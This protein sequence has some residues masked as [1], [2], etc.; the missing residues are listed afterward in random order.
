MNQPTNPADAGT[1]DTL[2]ITAFLQ[3]HDYQLADPELFAHLDRCE[4]CRR[5][6]DTQ[7]SDDEWRSRV[8][9]LLRPAEFDSAGSPAFSAATIVDSRHHSAVAAQEVLDS[10]APTDH[11]HHLGRIGTYEVTGVIGVGG[12]G[13]VL[14]AIDPA[15]D[16]VVAV[17]VMSPQLAN[18][19]LARKRF[20]REAKAAAAVLHPNV[21]PIHSVAHCDLGP[22]LVMAYIRGSSLQKRL[23]QEGALALV[24][25][26]RI[27]AQIAAGLAAAHEQGLVHR[28]IK[29]ENILLEDGVER[30]TITDFGLARAVDDHT[31]TQNGV[32]AGTPRYMSPEQARGEHVDQQS[33]LFSLGSVLYA[34][35]TG[36]PPFG[37]DSS[38]GVMRRII[39]DTPRPIRE[40][41]PEVPEWLVAIIGR[42]MAKDKSAR[43]ASASEVHTLLETCLGHV[44]QP[45]AIPAPTLGWTA[46]TDRPA[47][48]VSKSVFNSRIGVLMTL[49]ACLSLLAALVFLPSDRPSLTIYGPSSEANPLSEP[50]A[51]QPGP[52]L[53][54][55]KYEYTGSDENGKTLTRRWHMQGESVGELKVSVLHIQGGKSR[56]VCQSVYE[57]GSHGE[58]AIQVELQ[59]SKIGQP[60]PDPGIVITPALVVSVNGLQG[61]SGVSDQISIPGEF[62]T[63][64][65]T[66]S[67]SLAPGHVLTHSA[68]VPG[69]ESSYQPTVDSMLAASGQ[70]LSFLVV[71]VDWR[72]VQEV[73]SQPNQNAAANDHTL[74]AGDWQV[75]YSEDSGRIAPQELLKDLHMVITSDTMTMELGGHQSIFTFELDPR[76]TPKSI[77]MTENG[78]RKQGIYDLQGDTLRICFDEQSDNRPTAFDSQTDSA[79]DVVIML[80]RIKTADL[81][82][83]QAA[84]PKQPAV[85]AGDD[86]QC[87]QGTWQSLDI[88]LEGQQAP[89]KLV[90]STQVIFSDSSYQVVVSGKTTESCSYVLN[91]QTSPKAID[92]VS[93]GHRQLGIYRLD[94][95]LL[96]LWFAKESA[97]VRPT[98]YV[99]QL[100]ESRGYSMTLKRV[101]PERQ[102][103]VET[104]SADDIKVQ[105]TVVNASGQLEITYVTLVESA[106]FCPGAIGEN[107]QHGLEL[108]FVRLPV[109][110]KLSVT[111]PAQQTGQWANKIVVDPRG[112]PVLLRSQG[113]TRPIW[114]PAPQ[115]PKGDTQ[116]GE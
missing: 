79:N 51:A 13:V 45:A 75:V 53:Q 7:A 96:Q 44:Q 18:Q 62:S 27:G 8:A 78:R 83:D 61:R 77:D 28:D 58:Q 35:C 3:A 100:E 69:D 116:K 49:T 41:N 17:K 104:Y 112:Q 68:Y 111:Y 102:P 115:D 48:T 63:H 42:L 92:A 50:A 16:R 103:I 93:E 29:P 10:L 94:G 52:S 23:D 74:I 15:L 57:G 110:R 2:R 14:K 22:Y 73:T 25:V 38:L 65:S 107:T 80:K 12:M 59:T 32:I 1:C 97:P 101:I 85:K 99:N 70:G 20:A 113:E 36:Q 98:G 19:E 72:S 39:D 82:S 106:Y 87:I 64:A 43:F 21:I 11:P 95:D 76:T 26:L 84:E 46:V 40:L 56:T 66:E 91:P 9:E 81:P 37:A 55:V 105:E 47:P 6:L 24:E 33:D 54:V 4:A 88:E 114:M 31:V 109:G 5:E 90:Q 34:L 67:G 71:V 86:F 89:A 30:V 60:M 108:S